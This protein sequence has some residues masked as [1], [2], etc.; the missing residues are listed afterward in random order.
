MKK[1]TFAAIAAAIGTFALGA[2]QRAHEILFNHMSRSG[3][4]LHVGVARASGIPDY[5]PSGTI[6][7]DPE[8][9]SGKLV[10]KFYKTTVFGEICGLIV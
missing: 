4:V 6:R 1:F 2:A 7:F 3:L 8:L 9:Y 10:E 5:G